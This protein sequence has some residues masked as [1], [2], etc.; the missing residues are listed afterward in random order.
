M[1]LDPSESTVLARSS[2]SD[3]STVRA[4]VARTV[5]ELAVHDWL[6]FTYLSILVLAT[7]QGAGPHRDKCLE[8]TTG[9]LMLMVAS[10]ALVRGGIL[11]DRFF[12]PM[13]YRVGVY[14]TVQ[15]SYFVLRDL[16][17][18]VSSRALDEHLYALDVRVFGVEPT[19]WVDRF[20][21]SA[22]TEWF[23]FFYFN[24]FA[25]LAVHVLP[26]LF[27]TKRTAL[28]QEFALAVLFVFCTAHVLYMIVP[29]YGPYRLLA[30][31]Y[32]HALPRGTWYSL[33]LDA[34]NAGGA[35]KDIFPSLHTAAPTTI[36]LFSFRHR[37]KLPF[38]YSWPLVAFFAAN[39]IGATIFLRWHYAIDVL[40]GLT[41]ATVGVTL[42]A[43]VR[44]LEQAWRKRDGLGPVWPTFPWST[45]KA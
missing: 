27:V 16:L 42:A 3:E 7:L 14:G 28:L 10:M 13:L 4:W 30:D 15:A 29:G 41:L 21:S 43:R 19:L 17:P 12:A 6:V 18:T 36:A 26:M 8:Q 40:A 2:S 22:T 20:V 39:I 44:P 35:Q 32:Q 1:R 23:S 33:V 37:D 45:P 9:L 25:L 11:R 24:Y 5:R 38:K 31:Q 34:V